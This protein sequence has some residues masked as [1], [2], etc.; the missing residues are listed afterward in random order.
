MLAPEEIVDRFQIV[1][2]LGAGGIAQV[3][4]ARHRVLGSL[5][6]LTCALKA[7]S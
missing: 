7:K 3:Y 1:E 2:L 4:K 5:H 6:A